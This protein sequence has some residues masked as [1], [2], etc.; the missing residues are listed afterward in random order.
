MSK[1]N[2][3]SVSRVE[4]ILVNSPLVRESGRTFRDVIKEATALHPRAGVRFVSPGD[5]LEGE[6]SAVSFPELWKHTEK[7]V[8]VFSVERGYF[9]EKAVELGVNASYNTISEAIRKD[10]Y[11]AEPRFWGVDRVVLTKTGS[12]VA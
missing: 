4:E 11:A 7:E 2:F 8:A 9:E 1:I 10:I 12:V 6:K 5:V 3:V